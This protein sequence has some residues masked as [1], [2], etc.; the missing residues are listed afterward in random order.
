MLHSTRLW[1]SPTCVLVHALSP[2][3]VCSNVLLTEAPKRD[4][5]ERCFTV[6]ASGEAR[7]CGMQSISRS[8]QQAAAAAAA[9]LVYAG[10]HCVAHLGL[11]A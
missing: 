4:G 1:P 8:F 5:D 11:G 3:L 10:T 6:K 7:S 9:G 2:H